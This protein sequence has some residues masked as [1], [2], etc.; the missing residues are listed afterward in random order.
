MRAIVLLIFILGFRT[1]FPPP[2]LANNDPVNP[3]IDSLD[4]YS[5]FVVP[6]KV[7]L[8]T[9]KSSYRSGQ[10]I[11]FRAYLLDGITSAPV[12]EMNNLFVDL[13]DWRGESVAVRML[14][15]SSGGAHGDITLDSDLP[16]GNYILRAYTSWMRNFGE[17]YYF[18]M[19]MYIRNTNYENR[20][21][22]MEVFR[23]RRF[24]RSIE[25]KEN[26]YQAGFFPEGGNLVA[27]VVNRVA[28]KVADQLGKGQD[29]A[30]EVLDRNGNVVAR[31]RTDLG[32]IGVFEFEPETGNE[33]RAMISVNGGKPQRYSLPPARERG[34]AL[35]IDQHNGKVNIRLATKGEPG[36]E[37][38]KEVIIVGHTR[39]HLHFA[40]TYTLDNEILAV[41]LDRDI[42]PSGISHFTVFTGDYLPVAERLVFIDRNDRIRFSAAIDTVEIFKRDYITLSLDVTDNEGNPVNGTFSLSA[43]TGKPDLMNYSPGILTYVLF[44]SDLG[45]IYDHP[46]LF[47]E[48]ADD[49]LVMADNL[50][51]THGW[52]RF[53][54][55]DV[56]AGETPEIRYSG[57]PG[58]AIAGRVIDPAGNTPIKDHPLLL[59]IKNGDEHEF[60]TTSNDRG[61]FAFHHLYYEGV[62]RAELSG[63]RI[64]TNYPPE[65]KLNISEPWGYDVE[66]GVYTRKRLVTRR[67]E[68]W[69][70]QPRSRGPYYTG[71]TGRI[72]VAQE[73]GRPDQT[74]FL[75]H[76]NLV[77]HNVLELLQNKAVGLIVE[78]NYVR[79]SGLTSL[80]G[81]TEV[82]YMINGRFVERNWFIGTP[83]RDIERIEIFRHSSTVA[84]GS[85]GGS[86][87]VNLYTKEPGYTGLVDALRLN[88]QGYHEVRDF[89]TDV[90]RFEVAA[91]PDMERTI[92]WEPRLV[93]GP[94]G[95]MNF[96]IPVDDQTGIMNLVIQGAGYGGS[97]GYSRITILP[98]SP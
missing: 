66:P 34:Y 18:T 65:I 53:R 73:Y 16:D 31:L 23:N 14:L 93:S 58:I 33:Y 75:D 15:S 96:M 11:W 8:H 92:H 77:E 51:L 4:S 44:S 90:L 85:R 24:N 29:A 82:E 68:D 56:L 13:I 97:L 81:R 37:I 3:I 74:I 10:T 22:R 40:G 2:S 50:L 38:H 83:I 42:F 25:R 52:R 88:I 57:Q 30:G 28:F 45:G 46:G 60:T 48:Q 39:G 86:G 32:G 98:A 35:R 76:D 27:G 9:D 12:M 54:W 80:Y 89:Y 71:S 79:L 69:R 70:R 55:E 63:R 78:G 94:D 87:V 61:Y 91:N 62:F 72:A 67:G 47:I 84:F 17:E 20:I 6:Q 26:N 64:G 41:D 5:A 49:E 43:V 21:R 1:F 59:T 7:Y 95:T 36:K 19:P